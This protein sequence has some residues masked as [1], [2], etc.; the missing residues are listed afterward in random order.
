MF[1]NN[2]YLK[3]DGT[4]ERAEEI[5]KLRKDKN[6]EYGAITTTDEEVQKYTSKVALNQDAL[7]AFNM[8]ENTHRL[9]I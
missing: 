8:L 7:N 6:I 5:T 4:P 9:H 3:Y 2:K 1:L